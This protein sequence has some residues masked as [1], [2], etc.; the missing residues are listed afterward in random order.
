MITIEKYCLFLTHYYINDWFNLYRKMNF[1][2]RYL[3]S[4]KKKRILSSTDHVLGIDK[5]WFVHILFGSHFLFFIH[6]LVT[7]WVSCLL[8]D[9]SIYQFTHHRG[10]KS[11]KLIINKE[12]TQFLNK[13]QMMSQV[14]QQP[15]FWRRL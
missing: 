11:P 4:Q 5:V 6:K 13:Q 2:M 14:H 7:F 15:F 10:Y 3:T 1:F 9:T 12:R 8:T